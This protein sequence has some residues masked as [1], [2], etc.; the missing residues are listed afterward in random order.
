MKTSRPLVLIVGV[1]FLAVGVVLGG[2]Y[3]IRQ[4]FNQQRPIVIPK[5]S[6][7][8]IAGEAAFLANCAA[9]HGK[10]AA[11]TDKGPPLVNP[12]YS[13]AHHSDFSF[14]RAVALGVPQHH[15]L[16]GAMPA[17]PQMARQQIEQMIVYIRELQ[18]ANGIR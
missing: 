11:G 1:I 9:C 7:E 15:W 8:A 2:R 12:I 6:S 14:V 3:L 17:Q 13:A 10:N 16:F 18:K 5:L 4:R